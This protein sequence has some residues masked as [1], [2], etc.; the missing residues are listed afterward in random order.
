MLISGNFQNFI[1]ELYTLFLFDYPNY[2]FLNSTVLSKFH[3]K[4]EVMLIFQTVVSRAAHMVHML[5]REGKSVNAMVNN[6]ALISA[7]C[8]ATR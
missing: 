7:L 3:N 8:A 6:A 2:F 1:A 4:N 5:S